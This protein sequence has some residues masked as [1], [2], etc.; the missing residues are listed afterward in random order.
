M[1]ENHTSL[2]YLNFLS[3][4]GTSL[5]RYLRR[6]SIGQYYRRFRCEIYLSMRIDICL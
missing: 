4:E 3:E 2:K 5:A 6:I 1:V